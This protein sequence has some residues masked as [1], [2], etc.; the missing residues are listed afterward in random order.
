LKTFSA[1]LVYPLRFPDA[2]WKGNI[3]CLLQTQHSSPATELLLFCY[4]KYLSVHKHHNMM[5]ACSLSSS[6]TA[7]SLSCTGKLVGPADLL[8]GL[9]VLLYRLFCC[10]SLV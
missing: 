2:V 4:H 8:E 10:T 3:V 5:E 6:G 9:S 1:S 7:P